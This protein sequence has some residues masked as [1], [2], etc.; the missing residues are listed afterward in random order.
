MNRSIPAMTLCLV[1]AACKAGAPS[2]TAA[3]AATPAPAANT[4]P[5]AQ[6]APAPA[7]APAA[8]PVYQFSFAAKS[9]ESKDPR[10]V[11]W[12]EDGCGRYP[13]VKV[14][15]IPLSDPWLLPDSVVEFDA[16]GQELT[17]WGKPMGSDLIGL[18][19]QR[20]QFRVDDKWQRG[21]FATDASGAVEPITSQAASLYDTAKMVDCPKLPSFAQSD[22]EQ[23]F[24][25]KDASGAERRLAWEGPCT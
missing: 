14:D 10:I 12:G 20:L 15:S 13:I 18:D 7:A 4:E 5:A 1:L 2:D 3:P 17:R 25:I 9:E 23:C 19:G 22:A 8:K 24:V 16:K 11:D 6:P 21:A